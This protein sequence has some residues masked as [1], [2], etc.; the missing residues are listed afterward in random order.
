MKTETGRSHRILIA[1]VTVAFVA[2]CSGGSGGALTN[3]PPPPPPGGGIIGSGV[4]MGP[5]DNFGSIISGGR[6]YDTS[7]AVFMIDGQPGTEAEL[8]VG[9]VVAI[10]ADFNDDGLTGTANTATYN[11]NVEGPI[12]SIDTAANS[13]VVLGQTILVNT[14]TNFDDGISP[15]DVTGLMVND[16]VEVSGLVDSSGNITATRIELKAA[17]ADFEVTGVVSGLD[18]AMMLFNIN[19]LIVDYSAA[20]LD[21][22]PGGIPADGDLVEAKGTNF[23][24]GGEL[25]ATR[26]ERKDS[27]LGLSQ[28]DILEIEGFVTRFVSATDLDVSGQSVTTNAGTQFENGT[29]ADIALD[30]RMEV[31]G[32]IDAMG[33]LV[34]DEI[35]FEQA[36]DIRMD[37]IV[38]NVIAASNQLTIFGSVTVQIN[39]ETQMEDKRDN[40]RPLTINDINVG[41]YISVVGNEDAPGSQ[42]VTATRLDRDDLD[43]D[44]ILQGFVEAVNDPEYTV[45]GITIQTNAGTQFFD[46]N[47]NPITGSVFFAQAFG[48]LAKARGMLS[49]GVLVAD[50][51]EL[52][53]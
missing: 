21:N 20:T 7:G 41:D 27:A 10:E 51:V 15:H 2:A 44:S 6:E 37:A 50:E 53:N 26:V 18:A 22:F 17:G 4:S 3:P 42:S 47:D 46:D 12:S 14:L 34:A 8:E 31:E 36:N 28:D 48:R 38:D 23:G 40:V 45:L 49:G 1:L 24:G 29:A 33:L 11:D 19:N 30:I 16:I 43:P 9:H 52:Q 13:F 39:T 5:I 35:N 32:Q 25:L